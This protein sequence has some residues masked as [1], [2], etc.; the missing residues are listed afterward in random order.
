[1]Q[2][3]RATKFLKAGG[4]LAGLALLFAILVAAYSIIG[5]QRWRVDLTEQKLYTLSDG[6]R[7]VLKKLE[8]PVTLKLFFSRSSAELPAQ[9]KVYENQV[10][11]LLHEYR[12]ASGG[13]LNLEVLDPKPDSEAEEWAQSYGVA[14]Q[15]VEMF[16]QPVYF[17]IVAVCGD[18][19]AALPALDP[20]ADTLLEYNVTRLIHRVTH[21]KRPVVGVLSSLPVMGDAPQYG[22]PAPRAAR[23]WLAFQEIQGDY[24]L[25][26]LEANTTVIAPEIQTLILVHPKDLPQPTL[27]AI[28]Q[29]V[30]RGGHL[31]AFLD[32]MNVAELE[33]A[34]Q[35]NPFSRPDASSNLAPLLAAWGVTY[36]PGQVLADMKAVSRL[37]GNNNRVEESSVFLSLKAD[38]VNRKDVLT[39][40][41]NLIM[42]PFAGVLSAQSGDG[43]T[44]SPLL[45][46]SDMA[47][48]V[49]SLNAQFGPQEINRE[50]KPEPSRQNMALRLTGTFKTAF[51]DG[52]PTA[53]KAEESASA[54]VA[55]GQAPLK[56]G[57]STVIL[58]ADADLLF[59][60]FCVEDGG[61]FGARALNDNLSFFANAVEQMAG[62]SDLIGIRSRGEF[63]RPFDRV[64]A[65]EDVARQRW[66]ET[67]KDLVAKLQETRDQLAKLQQQKDDRQKL[68]L[69]PEQKEAIARYR[70]SEI[71]MTRQ[72]KDVRKNLR[73]DIE[74]LGFKVK[75]LNI[76][77]MPA[78]VVVGGLVYGLR[79]R[80]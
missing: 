18:T 75:I 34:P 60:R 7:S 28:D 33:S 61:I 43:L 77:L 2:T 22:M 50:F 21:P 1:M 38:N 76:V 11:D 71:Q 73:R 24:D 56:E 69:S 65:L 19:E 54:E 25:R 74:A 45:T 58:V 26:R 55:D 37:R 9:L 32:P 23:P 67:E 49:S 79:R 52:K 10:E 64:V 78:L 68:I 46:S 15:P 40:Q 31:L 8:Q 62:S 70:E 12:L 80:R 48:K 36:N 4:G 5:Q 41:L 39:S 6:T 3:T 44:V 13:K 14:P 59:D 20:R 29:F 16:G 17:G 72:L 42:L 35:S 51:P 66:Q 30:L 57:Q 63:F 53:E 47:G 27:Y